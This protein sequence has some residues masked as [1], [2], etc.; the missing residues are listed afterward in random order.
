[1]KKF[2]VLLLILCLIVVAAGV[3]VYVWGQS[4]MKKSLPEISGLIT[5]KGL[6]GPVD[7]YRDEYG[8]PHIYAQNTNDLMFAVGFVSAQ[9]RLWQMDLTRRAATGRLAE[10][11]GER[12]IAA[13]LLAR[14]IGF[15]HTAKQQLEKLSPESRTALE[16]FSD[17]VNACTARLS[18]LPPE[19]RLLKCGPD[20]W[21]PSDS[22]AISRLLAWQLS[23]N[24]KSELIM[25]RLSAKLGAKRAAE[26]GPTYPSGGPFIIPVEITGEPIALPYFDK[27]ARLLDE[28]VGTSGGSNSWV[29]GPSLSKSGAPILANDPHLSGT[30]MPSIWYFVHMVGGGYDVIGAVTPGLPLPLLGHNRRIGWGVT[31]MN[32][33]VQDIYI[34]RINPQD[35]NRYEYDGEWLNMD[36]RTERIRFRTEKGG[37]SFIEKEIRSTVHG[38]LV[39][40]MS[41]G[42]GQA[43]SLSW[44]GLEPTQD[45]EALAG[46]NRAGNWKEFTRALSGFSVA[47][48]NFIYADVDGNIGYYGA[49]TIPVRP[50]GDGTMPQSGWTSETKWEGRIPFEEMPHI[51]NPD[52][53]YIVTANNK[54]VTDEYRHFL[55][56]EWAPRYRYQR[57]AELIE[58]QP[59][60]DA[61]GL[62]RMQLDTKSLLAKLIVVNL[63]PALNELRDPA[64]A[65]AVTRLKEWDFNNTVDSV[66]ATIYHEFLLRFARNT[67]VDEMG[68]ELTNE[69]LDN[70]YLWLERFV[71]FVKEDSHWFDNVRTEE[72]ETRDDIAARSFKE[73][74]ASLR[75]ARG[76]DMSKWKW[77]RLHLIEFRHPLDRS[78]LVKKIFNLGPYPFPGDGETVNRG[79]F[80]FNEPYGVTM[81]ASIRHIMDFSRPNKTLGIHTTGQSGNPTSAHYRDYVDKWLK[82]EYVTMMMEREDF[83]GGVEGY[84]RLAPSD[85][86][87]HQ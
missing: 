27:G 1:L 2:L 82:G 11:F 9:E 45:F 6:S 58:R 21:R 15:D 63:T 52:A 48:Q 29:I 40:D 74:V 73:T 17:G 20:P 55:S 85:E 86:Q 32:A 12:L 78:R 35:Q 53:G 80:G 31:N 46:I 8:I 3:A 7:I 57:I 39:N 72:V 61:Q 75:E 19:F 34:E 67:F 44:T 10:I 4:E 25:L 83:I 59:P 62:A 41:P 24:Y 76:R 81:A 68:S 69:Y 56:A 84:L 71:Q 43:I 42:V 23:K 47:P 13:D 26:L 60:H 50:S 22:L 16:A 70:Y 30:R 79:T 36:I 28:I 49:G 33:D 64:L 51:F 14:T 54:V 37:L 77:G 5:L 38:P 87:S 66:P 65:E 18:S